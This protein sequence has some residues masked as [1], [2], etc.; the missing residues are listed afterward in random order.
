MA[1]E[2]KVIVKIL[3]DVCSP[4]PYMGHSHERSLVHLLNPCDDVNRKDIQCNTFS[5]DYYEE[6]DNLV[7]KVKDNATIVGYNV[8]KE[9]TVVYWSAE[10]SNFV[11]T[12][13]DGNG[14]NF[15]RSGFFIKEG[16]YYVG[17]VNKEWFL[18][19]FDG[20]E[21]AIRVAYFDL[22]NHEEELIFCYS[23]K[24]NPNDYTRKNKS[25]K[26]SPI[27]NVTRQ[28]SLTGFNYHLVLSIN[29]VTTNFK[30]G[31]EVKYY[32]KH[33]ID[34]V[35][36]PEEL[37]Y[38]HTTGGLVPDKE[39]DIYIP[40]HVKKVHFK[41]KIEYPPGYDIGLSPNETE[42]Y[43]EK[44]EITP[45]GNSKP[46]PNPNKPTIKCSPLLTIKDKYE[47]FN[48]WNVKLLLQS[49][50]TIP[51]NLTTKFYLSYSIDD[52]NHWTAEELVHTDTAGGT[53]ADFEKSLYIKGSEAKRVYFK[54]RVEYP[55][56]VNAI[57]YTN[58]S[59]ESYNNTVLKEQNN[60]ANRKTLSCAS[61]IEV[62]ENRVISGTNLE[63]TLKP[64]GL[65]S[66]P[67]EEVKYYL[68]RKN[69]G[70]SEVDSL[71]FTH[72]TG[73]VL[74][75]INKSDYIPSNLF[76][77]DYIFKLEFPS[78]YYFTETSSNIC[79]ATYHLQLK[80]P[81]SCSSLLDFRESE[82]EATIE[83]TLTENKPGNYKITPKLYGGSYTGSE[84]DLGH[85]YTDMGNNRFLFTNI[86]TSSNK[87]FKGV[88]EITYLDTG[89]VVGTCETSGYIT[90][91]SSAGDGTTAHDQSTCTY[92]S[93]SKRDGDNGKSK[94]VV[95]LVSSSLHRAMHD[96]FT[97][98]FFYRLKNSLNFN[99]LK[100]YN[101]ND[102]TSEIEF[103]AQYEST[104]G[105]YIKAEL[106]MEGTMTKMC[107]SEELL[108]E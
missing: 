73:G 74:S 36:Q 26:C 27:L 108:I 50:A 102:S 39:K 28:D 34:D 79:T 80:Q 35:E 56:E 66:L 37:V 54:F 100:E 22:D 31:E 81:V 92:L 78:N 49:R 43:D 104:E 86:D 38:T 52:E 6:G 14:G 99:Y 25:I 2:G 67:G 98:K 59:C 1:R 71:L 46:N 12:Q 60:N 13:G 68:E 103:S 91:D 8:S 75:H 24:K 48:G 5:F 30:V 57:G 96:R 23:Q 3:K 32:L 47:V 90:N 105:Y 20:K 82:R 11:H 7:F 95:D 40:G 85:S 19:N 33:S 88:V 89:I 84:Y 21:I 58:N 42:C 83:V 55:P 107:E 70:V 16:D 64:N 62:V 77:V 87:S 45:V 63:I 93:I 17:K 106:Y 53:V 61:M 101:I 18:R 10:D 97:L 69:D 51:E 72:T 9:F 15:N 65:E 29:D 41:F 94:A 4:I 44:T 76:A